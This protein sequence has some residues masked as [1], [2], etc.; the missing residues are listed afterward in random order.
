MEL[1][2]SVP[3]RAKYVLDDDVIRYISI[4]NFKHEQYIDPEAPTGGVSILAHTS[5]PYG[6]QHMDLVRALAPGRAPGAAS[7]DAEF[8]HRKEV[9]A[10]I[11]E[12]VT[13]PAALPMLKGHQPSEV[14]LLGWEESQV[15]SC[16]CYHSYMAIHP[17]LMHR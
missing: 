9:V 12:S 3:W 13:Q 16:G 1:L 15:C 5:V 2:A 7:A 4:E 11:L 10:E 8:Q 14:H 6:L 17:S